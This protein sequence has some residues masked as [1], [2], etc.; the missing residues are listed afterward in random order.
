ASSLV[1]FPSPSLTAPGRWV[2]G[3]AVFLTPPQANSG[4]V[5][6]LWNANCVPCHSVAGQ[7]G[8]A[9]PRETPDTRVAELGIACEACHGPGGEH[10]RVNGDPARRY[11][12]HLASDGDPTIVNPR[13]LPPER[14]SEVCGQ[15]HGVAPMRGLDAW[16]RRGPA[17]RPG[18]ALEDD[19]LL[20]GYEADPREP[21]KRFAAPG[22]PPYMD[23]HFW[24]DG[25]VRISG[26]EYNGL[27]ESR[28]AERGG[29]G[30]LSCHGMHRT[31]PHAQL[32]PSQPD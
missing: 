25:T 27:H 22:L 24:H 4:I 7:P 17:F 13:R 15:C 8:A 23:Q 10:V 6:R 29:L 5:P 26:R 20:I 19:R 30:C 11:A 28:C 21:W 1:F 18:A 9:T 16:R 14:A 31:D 3:A 12:R 2:P 32:K